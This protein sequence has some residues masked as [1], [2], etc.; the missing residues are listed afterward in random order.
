MEENPQN[1]SDYAKC[2]APSGLLNDCRSVLLTQINRS[3]A[4]SRISCLDQ[5]FV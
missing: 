1:V 4:G 3:M 5:T 2:M